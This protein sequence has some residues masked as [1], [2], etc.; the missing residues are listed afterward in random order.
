MSTRFGVNVVHSVLDGTASRYFI[1]LPVICTL[2]F[3]KFIM[4][5][6]GKNS[7]CYTDMLYCFKIVFLCKLIKSNDLLGFKG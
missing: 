5:W 4:E 2:L 7:Y 6:L 3:F 1:S